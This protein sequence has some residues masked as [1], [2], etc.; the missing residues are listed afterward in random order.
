MSI[1]PP[2]ILSVRS[3]AEEVYNDFQREIL[4]EKAASLGRAGK[5]LEAALARL[6][7][8]GGDADREALVQAAADAAHA[9]LIQREAAG[10][11]G[12]GAPLED[13]GVPGEVRVRI[14]ARPRAVTQ[15]R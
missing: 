5:A 10:I 1:Q 6:K 14:G 4:S 15:E 7:A 8:A 2:R 9:Y 13:F 3:R 12:L 11:H